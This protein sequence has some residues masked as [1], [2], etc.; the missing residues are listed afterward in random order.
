MTNRRRYF[1]ELGYDY[2]YDS[3]E[4]CAPAGPADAYDDDDVG[5]DWHDMSRILE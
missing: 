1:D 3:A 2:A 4:E 5:Y